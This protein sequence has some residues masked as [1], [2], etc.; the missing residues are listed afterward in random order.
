MSV[1]R[2][3]GRS[4]VRR[5]GLAPLRLHDL[6]HTAAA[7]AIATGAHPLEIKTRLGHASITTTLNV[8]GHLFKSLDERLAEELDTTHREAEEQRKA[9]PG[10]SSE[11]A[12]ALVPLRST[13]VTTF[14]QEGRIQVRFRRRPGAVS[15]NRVRVFSDHK[16]FHQSHSR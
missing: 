11:H 3:I 10:D 9:S 16:E 14:S 13:V 4:L 6:R 2:P 15:P 5:A 12:S 8:Y 7:L 1:Y